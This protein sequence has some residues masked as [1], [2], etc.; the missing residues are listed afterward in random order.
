MEQNG[1]VEIIGELG[2]Y[3]SC[4][5]YDFMGRKIG[6]SE[7]AEFFINSNNSQIYILLIES[8]FG[9]ETYKLLVK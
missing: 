9:K 3:K 7:Y 5:V 6:Y 1:L 8:E 4:S 2:Y